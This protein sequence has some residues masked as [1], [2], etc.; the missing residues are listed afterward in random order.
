M[1]SLVE[2]GLIDCNFAIEAL[3]HPVPFNPINMGEAINSP[4]SEYFP[5]ITV[6]ES[7]FIYTRR[8]P[9]KMS[10]SGFNEDFYVSHKSGGKWE[11]SYNFRSLNSETND[12]APSISADGQLLIFTICEEFGNYGKAKKGYGSCDLV[13]S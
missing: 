11:K 13:Y 4:L 10:S 8:L 5:S 7:L 3:K 12:G 1:K 6:D 9:S 2:K